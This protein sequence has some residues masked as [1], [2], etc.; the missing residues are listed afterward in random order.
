[1][2]VNT[3]WAVD[4]LNLKK[5]RNIKKRG[6]HQAWEDVGQQVDEGGAAQ[7]VPSVQKRLTYCQESFCRYA[8]DQECFPGHHDVLQRV[9]EVWKHIN[10]WY[11]FLINEDVRDKEHEE[12]D[13]TNVW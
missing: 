5:L 6:A 12:D 10:V 2:E 7:L 13:I 11:I 9:Q 3:F 8:H 4:K 1:M